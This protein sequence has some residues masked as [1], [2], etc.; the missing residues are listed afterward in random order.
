[1]ASMCSYIHINDCITKID[2]TITQQITL[3]IE[4]LI[5][6]MLHNIFEELTHGDILGLIII[7]INNQSI[8]RFICINV[9][10]YN[11]GNCK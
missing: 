10:I 3:T 2:H 11:T 4:V 1:M 5:I 8:N 9:F 6:L 7:I